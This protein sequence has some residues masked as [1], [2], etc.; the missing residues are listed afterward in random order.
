MPE[1]LITDA[2]SPT[3]SPEGPQIYVGLD[4][5]EVVFPDGFWDEPTLDLV[6]RGRRRRDWVIDNLALAI[7]ERLREVL[8]ITARRPTSALVG[9]DG[10]PIS[11]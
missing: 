7:A 9:P 11:T 2:T 3:Q 10:R 8:V 1:A 6:V 4:G 5:I